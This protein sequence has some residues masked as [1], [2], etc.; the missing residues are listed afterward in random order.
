MNI[1]L[2]EKQS[3][4][5]KDING[6]IDTIA[7]FICNKKIT[8]REIDKANKALTD[9]FGT[10]TQGGYTSPLYI[11][12]KND[13]YNM[14]RIVIH[15]RD[16]NVNT[17]DFGCAY[18]PSD[19]KEIYCDSETQSITT[20]ELKKCYNTAKEKPTRAQIEKS[21]KKWEELNVKIREIENKRSNLI[22]HYYF[23]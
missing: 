15:T 3:K 7:P 8:K 22:F 19:T 16:R 6:I 11:I 5:N 13:N 23:N 21:F 10:F 1:E 20:E 14:L 4:F 9:K 17:G 12:W 2:L 18:I